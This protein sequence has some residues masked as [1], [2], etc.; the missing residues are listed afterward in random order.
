MPANAITMRWGGEP[1]VFALPA[2]KGGH[3]MVT[4][5]LEQGLR[6][7]ADRLRAHLVTW[8]GGGS[9]PEEGSDAQLLLATFCADEPSEL[10]PRFEASA[11][12]LAE[13]G[14]R[15]DVRMAG[16][17]HCAKALTHAIAELFATDAAMLAAAQARLTWLIGE[18]DAALVRGFQ[19]AADR[20]AG[21]EAERARRG[22]TRL[23]ALRRINAA[24]NSTLD[25]R[26]TLN[27]A[28]RAVA[29]ELGTDLC[30]IFL[31]DDIA[32]E[33]QLRATNGPWPRGGAHFTLRLG[34]GYSGAVAEHG[35]PLVVRDATAD[36]HFA[37][38]STAYPVTYHGLLSMPI[39]FFTVEKLVGV[40][41]VQTTAPRDFTPEEVSFLEVVAGQL[42]VNIENGRLYEQT[43]ETLRRKV[44]E[45]STLH[46]VSALVAS[47][48]EIKDVLQT[49]VM[50]A[51]HLSGA[52]RSIIFELDRTL[53]RLRPVAEHGFDVSPLT[54]PGI[55]VGQCC[56][57]RAVKSGE[58][59]LN[60]DC[61]RTDEGCFFRDRPEDVADQHSVLCV[62]LIS[63]HGAQGALCVFSPQRYLLTE[64]QRQLVVT[65][66]NV[67]AIAM[68]NAR[69]FE[70]TRE[71]LKTKGVLLREMHHRVKNNLQQ[72]ASILSMQRRRAKSPVV[73]RVLAES[74]GRIQGIAA[75]H[76]LL[77]RE[78]LGMAAVDDIA[79]KIVG[80]VQG[81]LV[82]PH[83]QLELQVDPCP[84][85][86]PSEQAT[87]LAIVLNE[88][89]AN[90]IEHGFAERTRGHIRISGD[91][92]EGS[93]VVRVADDGARLPA[94]FDLQ[95]SEGLGLQVVRSLVHSDLQGTFTLRRAATPDG[96]AAGGGSHPDHKKGGWTVAE[97]AFPAVLL[98]D[99]S[100]DISEV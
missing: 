86:V 43:D 63:M 34:E 59:Q 4:Q 24:A 11:L 96:K 66:A 27:T 7:H 49:I 17:H 73:E 84:A 89:I 97:L 62:P 100:D 54:R 22:V 46:R 94:D 42:A 47:T 18:V 88:L 33:L 45:L 72:V 57:G 35:H 31:F 85:H 67:A 56:A 32:R 87:T 29:E 39:I 2:A 14:G 71:G 53:Q 79:R 44:H 74:I 55:L 95:A 99:S 6:A 83:L 12:Q 13:H 76:D 25:L 3:I 38:E 91:R 41:S 77:S 16:I 19:N 26:E 1:R 80:I 10:L 90:A 61:M 65:F 5:S 51:V 64:Q 78:Q 23:Q 9:Q 93:I 52:E 82:P 28:V 92:Q 15:L 37:R 8:V 98:G 40:I 21:A 69:L 20:T 70:Q 75:T 68:E 30:S 48:L 50:Q 81:N 60:L 36:L 58:P